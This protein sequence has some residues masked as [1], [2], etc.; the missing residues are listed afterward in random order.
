MNTVAST[1]SSVATPTPSFRVESASR[2]SPAYADASDPEITASICGVR[3]IAPPS[4]AR[5]LLVTTNRYLVR[6]RSGAAGCATS[7]YS[8]KSVYSSFAAA[9]HRGSSG[10]AL[11]LSG[12]ASSTSMSRK[13]ASASM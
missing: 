12:D 4:A 3:P 1:T 10:C 5:S 13:G 8:S 9:H 6:G 11:P 2:T 7:V